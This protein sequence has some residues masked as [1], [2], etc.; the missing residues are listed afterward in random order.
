MD[1]SEE[2]LVGGEDAGAACEGV[3]CEGVS[4]RLL[5]W[6]EGLDNIYLGEILDMYVR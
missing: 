5:V 3:A 2:G 4:G 6:E 1:Y